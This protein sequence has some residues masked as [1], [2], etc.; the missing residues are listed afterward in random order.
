[1]SD[2]DKWKVQTLFFEQS[3]QLY[4]LI[5]RERICSVDDSDAEIEAPLFF[6]A[7]TV[8][9]NFLRYFNINEDANVDAK[10]EQIMASPILKD[11]IKEETKR[12]SETNMVIQEEN[13][14]K[15]SILEIFSMAARKAEE[16]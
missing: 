13:S 10:I 5:G 12:F 2:C 16:P 9:A 7:I 3:G 6:V 1:M 15:G 14:S 11:V 4:L 8:D